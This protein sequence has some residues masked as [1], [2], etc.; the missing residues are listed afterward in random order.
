MD[1]K[2]LLLEEERF[3]KLPV[4]LHMIM[5]HQEASQR[6]I[7][8]YTDT[9]PETLFAFLSTF[10]TNI[11]LFS[12]LFHQEEIIHTYKLYINQLKKNTRDM[13]YSPIIFIQSMAYTI[14]WYRSLFD[15]KYTQHKTTH[16]HL[17]PLLHNVCTGDPT[18][19]ETR[20]RS[21]CHGYS[22]TISHM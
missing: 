16:T 14:L 7:L 8:Y 5:S 6:I 4:A 1:Y 22:D 17:T 12:I 3:L 2:W 20:T 19:S 15:N 18:I 10:H 11:L 13:M 9:L 21:G